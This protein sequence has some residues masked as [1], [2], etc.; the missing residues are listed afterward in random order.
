[1]NPVPATPE[2]TLLTTFQFRA[3]T[4]ACNGTTVQVLPSAGNPP[5]NTTILS[6]PA[7]NVT[8]TFT[9][10][11]V[12]IV[13]APDLNNDNVVNNSDVPLFVDVLLGID[14]DPLRVS[15]SDVNCDG[16]ANGLDID[17]FV[18]VLLGP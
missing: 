3:L 5:Q 11:V 4:P 13:P 6:G 9:P 8:G 14:T 7:I 12:T 10:T 15:R 2:G 17:P 16:Q 18:A 1:M